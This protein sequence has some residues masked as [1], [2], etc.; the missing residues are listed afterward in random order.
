M[1]RKY[2]SNRGYRSKRYYSGNDSGFNRPVKPAIAIAIIAAVL[3]VVGVIAL[4]VFGPTA[5]EH[6][7]EI[8][9]IAISQMPAKTQ[10]L[11]GE[12]AFFDDLEILVTRN[13][14]KTF[15]VNAADCEITGFDSSVP[16][17]IQKITVK[18]QNHV[19]SFSVTI[20]ERPAPMRILVGIRLETLPK[21]KYKLGE[22]LDT[23]GGVLVCEYKDGT[24]LKVPLVNGY[25]SGFSKIKEPGT[26]T[27]KVVYT[28]NGLSVETTYK[29][30]VT[31]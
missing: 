21:T 22:S 16:V 3:V 20:N 4:I 2:R 26:H 28:E 12:R 15:T 8:G 23:T 30:T 14:G 7:K 25:V 24:T 11:T 18:Y 13:D 9:K 27:L 6:G 19:T 1:A 10:Y 17:T 5:Y 29:I 31:N